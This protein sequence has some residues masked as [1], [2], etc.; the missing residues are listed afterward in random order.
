[1]FRCLTLLLALPLFNSTASAQTSP[2]RT[3]VRFA[4][5]SGMEVR[6]YYR[7][8][9]GKE[10]YSKTPLEAPARYPFRQGGVYRLKLSRIPGHP[11]L[12]LYPTLDVPVPGPQA[13]EFLAHNAVTLTLNAEDLREV[14]EGKQLTKTIYLPGAGS[15]SGMVVLVLRIGN[16]D[17]K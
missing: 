1:M 17:L 11:G 12:D 3:Q 5:P 7:T 2:P 14:L 8:T 16:V 15:G 9:D 4:G 6:W 10:E 13:Q